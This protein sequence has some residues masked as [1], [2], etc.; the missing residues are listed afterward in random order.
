MSANVRITLK[1]VGEEKVKEALKGVKDVLIDLQMTSVAKEAEASAARLKIFRDEAK[2]RAK[3]AKQIDK[4]INSIVNGS[5]RAGAGKR[6]RQPGS[7]EKDHAEKSFF[8]DLKKESMLVKNVSSGL[9]SL[10][11]TVGKTALGLGLMAGGVALAVESLKTFSGFLIKDVVKPAWALETFAAQT[12]NATNGQIRSADL[13]AKTRA[14]QVKYNIDALDAAKSIAEVTD[15]T[16]N[17][18]LA[19]DLAET[20]AQLNKGYGVDTQELA[21]LTGAMYKKGMT[22]DDIKTG[23]FTQLKQGMEGKITLKEIAGLGGSFTQNYG[24]LRGSATERFSTLGAALQTGGITGKA[25]TSMNNINKFIE[26]VRGGQLGQ[27]S[28]AIVGGEVDLGVAIREALVKSKGDSSK[29]KSSMKFTDT[30]SDFLTQYI[31]KFNEELAKNGKDFKKAAEA[32]TEGFENAKTQVAKEAEVRAAAAKVMRTS[33][34]QY[35][36]AM[37]RIKVRMTE[38]MPAINSFVTALAAKAPQLAAAALTLTKV[39]IACGKFLGKFITETDTRTQREMEKEERKGKEDEK[40]AKESNKLAALSD[41][42]SAAQAE[43]TQKQKEEAEIKK[44][45]GAK[46]PEAKAAADATKTAQEKLRQIDSEVTSQSEKVVKANEEAEKNKSEIDASYSKKMTQEDLLGVLN[47]GASKEGVQINEALVKGINAD[48]EGYDIDNGTLT[49][50]KSPEQRAALK[51]YRDQKLQE[52][53]D[54]VSQGAAS[55]GKG[56]ADMAAA[57][58]ASMDPAAAALKEAA[59]ELKTAAGTERS[60]KPLGQQGGK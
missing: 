10:S 16:G 34:E 39:F 22:G 27:G 3:I 57:I 46:S 1:T 13:M 45:F 4:E 43:L 49:G 37:N 8:E 23:L 25:D 30:A 17:A 60:G 2:E 54:N 51:K 50:D 32:A 59:V 47:K 19:M 6:S 9:N 40:A 29:F 28:K 18:G 42:Q 55:S 41:K 5:S 31:P 26:Q 36:Q 52:M 21:G 48:P 12:E 53:Q 15:K 56:I 20:F 35:E 11:S 33:G 14:L 24:L 58:R 44:K 38:A 7:S